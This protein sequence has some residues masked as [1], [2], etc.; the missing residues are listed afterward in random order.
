MR[1]PPRPDRALRSADP[2][3]LSRLSW[4]GFTGQA[5]SWGVCPAFAATPEDKKAYTDPS[6]RGALAA[7]TAPSARTRA[8]P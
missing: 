6:L 8:R 1:M 3:A 4:N 5:L 2:P 7:L